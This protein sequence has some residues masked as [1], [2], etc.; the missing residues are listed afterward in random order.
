MQKIFNTKTI[1]KTIPDIISYYRN[2]NILWFCIDIYAIYCGFNRVKYTLRRR[3]LYPTEV[4]GQ[5]LISYSFCRRLSNDFVESG[6]VE[7][8]CMSKG[9]LVRPAQ[10]DYVWYFACGSYQFMKLG[11]R[12][13][14][15]WYF[16]SLVPRHKLRHALRARFYIRFGI[17]ASASRLCMVFR[18]RYILIQETR[19]NVCAVLYA[20][21]AVIAFCKGYRSSWYSPLARAP[22]QT[23]ARLA[24]KRVVFGT[25][26][27]RANSRN[28]AQC[29][30][31][32]ICR[33]SRYCILQR[34]CLHIKMRV[35][36]ALA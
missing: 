5:A 8:I 21:I 27:V 31:G 28:S 24:C 13:L 3:T 11:T 23:S 34:L 16:A 9:M 36:F 35:H 26:Y 25:H 30:C 12:I 14:P 19:H 18:L 10:A 2:H 15:L 33:H 22:S 6:K 4:H 32:F 20:G 1:P 29:L 7:R 17:C